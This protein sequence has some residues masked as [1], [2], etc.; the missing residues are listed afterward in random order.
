MSQEDALVKAGSVNFVER[1]VA[2]HELSRRDVLKAL[3]AGTLT[4]A[5]GTLL[6]A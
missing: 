2:G 4:L 6:E 5:G 3:G 1:L